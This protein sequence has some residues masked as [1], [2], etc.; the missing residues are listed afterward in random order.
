MSQYPRAYAV[1]MNADPVTQSDLAGLRREFTREIAAVRHQIHMMELRRQLEVQ[2]ART[3]TV[4]RRGLQAYFAALVLN[5]LWI[6][7]IFYWF[8]KLLGH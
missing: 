6:I 7:G 2:R 3:R 8:A 5:V 1:K 4:W